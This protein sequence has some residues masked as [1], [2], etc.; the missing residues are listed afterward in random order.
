MISKDIP[1][2]TS[3]R[4]NLFQI[5]GHLQGKNVFFFIVKQL[6]YVKLIKLMSALIYQ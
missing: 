3:D 6:F 2:T 4:P 5:K 1:L